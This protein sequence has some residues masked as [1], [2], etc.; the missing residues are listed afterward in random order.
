MADVLIRDVPDDVVAALD[1]HA[2]RL[3]L[4]RS[5]YVQR[6]KRVSSGTRVEP[7]PARSKSA[8]YRCDGGV[9]HRAVTS[10]ATLVMSS[11]S[12]S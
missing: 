4:S 2:G 12:R 7:Q 1:A 5:H 11:K 3:G 8:C 9:I 10:G 6:L